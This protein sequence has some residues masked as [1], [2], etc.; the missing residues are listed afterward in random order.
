MIKVRFAPSP[1]GF[2]HLGSARTAL[3]NWLYARRTGGTYVLR[4]EDTDKERSKEEFLNEILED[5]KWLGLDWD[6]DPVFQSDRFDIYRQKA[7]GLVEQGKAYMEGS[8]IIFRVEKG[9][10]IE[11]DDMIHGKIKFNT[12]ELKDQVMIKSDG[13]PAYNFCCVVDDSEMGITHIIRGDDHISNTPKQM[14]FY[15]AFGCEPPRFGHM[16][17]MMGTDG[18]KLSKRHGG[19]SVEEYRTEGFLPQALIN[20][21]ML[22]GWSPGEE[23]EVLSLGEAIDIF[24]ISDMTGVQAKFDVQKLRWLNGEYIMKLPLTELSGLL[25][26][27]VKKAGLEIS[28]IGDEGFAKLVELYRM[29]IKT[30]SEFVPLTKFFFSDEFEVDEKGWKKYLEDEGNRDNLREFSSRLP[31]PD[32]FTHDNIEAVCR[33]IAEERQLKAAQIIH[34]TRMAISGITQGAGLFEMMELLGREKTVERMEK[35]ASGR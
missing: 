22:L 1:T 31:G 7:E 2:L 33:A 20:Y 11:I 19:V 5:L 6:G 17:L 4:I 16:P 32:Q 3:F 12:D 15:E 8:A 35:A 21:L 34:P 26:E 10:D 29:R 27:R 30:L 14:L 25:S 23:R 24:D 9:R 13:S 18:A 28:S